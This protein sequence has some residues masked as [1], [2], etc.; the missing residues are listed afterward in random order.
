MRGFWVAADS[1]RTGHLYFKPNLGAWGH[2]IITPANLINP[3]LLLSLTML[4]VF[5]SKKEETNPVEP[6][7][8]G[9]EPEMMGC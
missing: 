1:K 5:P 8:A 7:P 3:L 9:V 2:G 4:V 6:L